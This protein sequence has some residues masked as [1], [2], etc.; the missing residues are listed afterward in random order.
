MQCWRL[1]LIVVVAFIKIFFCFSAGFAVSVGY[2]LHR[3]VFNQCS[4]EAVGAF[5][6]A[7]S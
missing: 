5:G 4:C 6:Q 1:N 2:P 7:G 3:N